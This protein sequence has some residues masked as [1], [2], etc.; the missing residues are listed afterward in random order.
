MQIGEK[1]KLLKPQET[2][3]HIAPED[4]LGP[5]FRECEVFLPR[6][7]FKAFAVPSLK[8]IFHWASVYIVH[9]FSHLAQILRDSPLM[10]LY[11]EMKKRILNY[12]TT[13]PWTAG[14]SLGAIRL[15]KSLIFIIIFPLSTV[16]EYCDVLYLP[17]LLQ[18]VF[19]IIRKEN[20]VLRWSG[21]F[22]FFFVLYIDSRLAPNFS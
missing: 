5:P 11:V 18:K 21:P 14:R 7:F 9:Y 8:S 6:V 3:L 12:I 13:V 22:C 10:L 15:R 2:Y 20:I 19:W 4:P 17:L 16:A 1:V